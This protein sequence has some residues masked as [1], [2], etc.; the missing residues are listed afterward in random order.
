MAS[1]ATLWHCQVGT[2][3]RIVSAK[4]LGVQ[5]WRRGKEGGGEEDRTRWREKERHLFLSS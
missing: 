1:R 3:Y 4:P 2:H 5:V